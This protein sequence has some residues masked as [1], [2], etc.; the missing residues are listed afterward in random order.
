VTLYYAYVVY[1]ACG[2]PIM[3]VRASVGTRP[4]ERH[5][6]GFYSGF[7]PTRVFSYA[8]RSLSVQYYYYYYNN[9]N[10][11]FHCDF[12][13]ILYFIIM[14]N[15]VMCVFSTRN[16]VRDKVSAIIRHLQP[17]TVC[18]VYTTRPGP[19]CKHLPFLQLIISQ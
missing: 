13:R 9:N 7:S 4:E 19:D 11:L 5:Y 14:Y 12:A 15:D 17:R 3:C 2:V 1:Y 16:R 18:V 6:I 10:I 8:A